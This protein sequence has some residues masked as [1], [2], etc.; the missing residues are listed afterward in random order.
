MTRSRIGIIGGTFDPPHF[1]HLAAA[2]EARHRLGLERLVWMV[3]RTPPHK[4]DR[5]VTAAKHRFHMAQ[6]ATRDNQAYE[7]SEAELLRE[8]PSYTVDTLRGLRAEKPDHDLIFFIGSDEFAAFPDWHLAEDV[9]RLAHLAVLLRY[10]VSFNPAVVEAA[11][12]TVRG[13]YSVVPVP[14]L[15]IS[16]S[17]LRER[18]R[19]GL[20]IRY[21]VPEP[22]R[23]YIDMNALYR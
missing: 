6:L 14:N 23:E 22:V 1:G 16:S 9:A 18:V 2:E 20:P 8:G 11:L 19:E 10:G 3:A 7:V 17:V 21:L 5:V 12:P 15:P 13:R 4:R